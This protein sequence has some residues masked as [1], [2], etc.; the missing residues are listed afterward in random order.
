MEGGKPRV[1]ENS[2]GDRTTPSVVVFMEDG[3]ITVGQPA[4]RQAVTNPHNTLFAVKRLIGR[5]FNEPEVQKDINLSCPTKSSRTTMAM[6]GSRR[7]TRKWRRRKFRRG[8][9]E[10]EEDRRGLSR[11]SGYRSGDHGTGLLQRQPASGHQG[12][13]PHRRSG[14]QAHH[15][16]ADGGGAGF[17]HGQ[18]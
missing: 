16:R 17:R 1:I 13:R 2:E 18:V 3:E 10:D 15:Q 6:P 12:R 4:K 8:T 9:D 14:S 5:R 11:P 7:A